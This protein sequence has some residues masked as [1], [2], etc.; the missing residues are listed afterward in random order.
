MLLV[1]AR[2]MILRNLLMIL[3]VILSCVL[4]S[5]SAQTV[6]QFQDGD[7]VAF[8]G[9]SITHAGMYHSYVYLYYLTRFPEREVR[10][11]NKGISG[12][13]A[14]HV[15]HRF[16]EDVAVVKPNV[17]TV[18]LGMNDVGRWLYGPDKTDMATQ[19]KFLDTYYSDMTKLLGK[20]D[21]IG[22]EVV[23]ITPTIYDQT[24]ELE[25]KNEVGVNDAL[26]KCANFVKTTAASRGQ[27][28][29]DFYD[30]MSAI[31]AEIQQ[32]DPSATI[33]GL[34][35]VHPH[36][37][38]G[39]FIM[40][41]QFLKA[42]AVPKFVSKMVL[43]AKSGVVKDSENAAVTELQ[44][45]VDSVRFTALE[46][47]LP[48]PQT[49]K[50]APAL[51]RVPFEAEMNQQILAVQNLPEGSYV[52]AI[53]GTQISTW[54]AAQLEAGINLAVMQKTP[55]YQQA[56]K[57]KQLNDTRHYQQGRLRNAAYVFYSSGLSQSDVD[58][59]DTQAVEVF[60][61]EKLKQSEGETWHNYVKQ[62]YN[63][64]VTITAK[65]AEIEAHLE[66]LHPQLYQANQPV[67]HQY[68]LTK[69]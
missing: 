43:D 28:Y 55:Q 21:A 12:E 13:K 11:W 32:D 40:G 53:D 20:L 24:A 48:F 7:R 35:R 63:D 3:W 64:Y 61:A 25:G 27:G 33:I 42:Q 56:L 38:L 14:W 1:A 5:A 44:V 34:D 52:L 51:E 69:Q 59:S 15:L 41:Y 16:D 4:P 57:V 36:V 19:Q 9:D 29:V 60:L 37:D 39:H 47:A 2:L 17:S 49:E 65:Q 30:S 10:I 23:F 58:L 67:S 45:A 46:G 6:R 8:V 22:S 68:T 18:M 26:G 50:I 62:Q 31:N 66:S 54:T